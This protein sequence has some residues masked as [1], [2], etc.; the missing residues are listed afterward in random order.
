LWRVELSR[1][2]GSEEE[3][4]EVAMVEWIDSTEDG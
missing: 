1:G 3:D 4:E 2:T